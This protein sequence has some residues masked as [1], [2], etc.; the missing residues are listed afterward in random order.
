MILIKVLGSP[1]CST[2]ENSRE[3]AQA[4]FV[5][6]VRLALNDNMG[7]KQA[8][9]VVFTPE[10]VVNFTTGERFFAYVTGFGEFTFGARNSM[11]GDVAGAVAKAVN[12]SFYS[13]Y[14]RCDKKFSTLCM[15][16]GNTGPPI[17]VSTSALI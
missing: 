13:R 15:V 7:I 14:C 2:A 11:A 5:R 17:V 9:N 4:T 3:S 8:V 10:A 12:A 16:N 1:C 6:Q